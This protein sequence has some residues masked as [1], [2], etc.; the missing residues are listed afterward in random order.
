[1]GEFYLHIL[2]IL[3]I[4]AVVYYRQPINLIRAVF[5][6]KRDQTGTSFQTVLP[7]TTEMPLSCNSDNDSER[8]MPLFIFPLSECEATNIYLMSLL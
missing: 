6:L 8:I 3:L 1:M 4:A 7:S 5:P 2:N